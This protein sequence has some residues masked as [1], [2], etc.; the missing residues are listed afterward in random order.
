[1][2]TFTYTSSDGTEYT[3]TFTDWNVIQGPLKTKIYDD[4]LGRYVW[5]TENIAD[6]T[7][8]NINQIDIAISKGEKVEIKARTISEAGY[9][10]NPLRSDW[11]NSIIM[12]FPS[13]L[14]TGNEMA[15]LIKNVN[16]DALTITITNNLDSLGVT[17]HLDDTIPN[18]NSV[19][20]MYFKHIAKNIAVEE[21]GLS[22]AGTTVV[23]SVSLQDVIDKLK[24]QY[25]AI[26]EASENAVKVANEVSNTATEKHD[27]YDEKIAEL[28]NDASNLDSDI[29]DVSADLHAIV[30][31]Q[32]DEDGVPH[33][34]LKAKKYIV[35]DA[36]NNEKVALV[37]Q[38]D[39]LKVTNNTTND[40]SEPSDILVKDVH[41]GTPENSLNESLATFASQA[42]VDDLTTN[43]RNI[44]TNVVNLTTRADNHDSDINALRG[45]ITTAEQTIG[46]Y[47][48]DV[49][50]KKLQASQLRL[51]EDN[52][53]AVVRP[54]G[55]GG[56]I[57]TDSFSGSNLGTVRVSDV[58]I[59]ESMTSGE[60][61]SVK[62]VIADVKSN[63]DSIDS[64][65][66]QYDELKSDFDSIYTKT[67]S[68]GRL[69][70]E[71][72][73][74][75]KL[76]ADEVQSNDYV[77]TSGT[78]FEPK[79]S[80]GNIVNARFANVLLQPD[81]D[82]AGA[83]ISLYSK[84]NELQ[85]YQ[86]TYNGLI[87]ELNNNY[88]RSSGS[89]DSELRLGYLSAKN[90]ITVPKIMLNSDTAKSYVIAGGNNDYIIINT[91]DG[92]QEKTDAAL[93]VYDVILVNPDAGSNKISVRDYVER[94]GSFSG[95]NKEKFTSGEGIH[96]IE[97]NELENLMMPKLNT[98]E[99][100]KLNTLNLTKLTT[101]NLNRDMTQQSVLNA[102]NMVM[103][104]KDVTFLDSS[105][106]RRNLSDV[107]RQLSNS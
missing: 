62:S 93:G 7:E 59:T 41:L 9:P 45:R 102:D 44:S 99:A 83:S 73:N 51:N 37:A 23:N 80:D 56:I 25:T 49:T 86:D 3:G 42:N 54:N 69:A 15:D 4:D 64:L 77:L 67:G 85:T 11:S 97:M 70:T 26:V 32:R 74:F 95:A 16:D 68:S 104:V 31:I 20:G 91:F 40:F 21:T 61:D 58:I 36:S 50:T 1:M 75:T 105:G 52:A 38:N 18:T 35:L 90:Q 53:T 14:A 34:D 39:L 79:D 82:N 100:E 72:G 10:E 55:T 22:D 81:I 12:E 47:A 46:T 5:K 28:T 88:T 87:S 17:T 2:N 27:W 76:S 33:A 96:T 101:I 8:T 107:I 57:V 92:V 19:N 103:N 13:T 89:N 48:T 78:T 94:L 43:V 66:T 29:K 84:I 65:N 98:F 60:S 63:S 6:G 30:R 24:N 106:N 71:N